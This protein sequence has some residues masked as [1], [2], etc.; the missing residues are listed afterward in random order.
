MSMREFDL[1]YQKRPWLPSIEAQTIAFIE[2]ARA[3]RS[4]RPISLELR[5]Q[6]TCV[7][8][9]YCA[10]FAVGDELIGEVLVL[11]MIVVAPRYRGRGWFTRYMQLCYALARDGLVIESVLHARLASALTRHFECTEFQPRNYLLRKR[12][13]ADWLHYLPAQPDKR[14]DDQPE[15]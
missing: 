3:Q 7:Y 13:A 11:A 12:S 9:R 5:W 8:L 14:Q 15:Y 10:N 4:R 1:L 2:A 6:G